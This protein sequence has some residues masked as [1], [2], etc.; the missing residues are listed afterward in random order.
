MS[1][2]KIIPHL[3]FDSA[4]EDAAKFYTSLVPGSGIGAVSRY[5]KAGF[6]VHGQ[7]EGTAMNVQMHLGGQPMI[8]LNGGPRFR[9]TPAVSY[10][11][12][13]DDRAALDHAWNALGAG[14]QIHMPLDTYAWAPRYGWLD[15]RWGVSWQ[16]S[17]GE[18][19][20]TG[21]QVMT[22]M[23]LFTGALAGQAEAAVA[24]YTALFPASG[25]EGIL[26]HDGSGADPAGTVMHAQFQLAGQTFM[27]GDSALAHDFTFTEANSFL[28]FCDDQAEIDHYWHALTSVP[29]AERCG[30]L[31]DRFGLSWQIIPRHL[32][33]LLSSPEP[34]V[35]ET[36]LSMGKIDIATLE[37][38]AK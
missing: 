9:P 6:E 10:F 24:Q 25:I 29:E 18:R 26:R 37:R 27:A 35:M 15:D 32:P 21:G 20:Q 4:A 8:A 17:L 11:L 12:T 13:F 28:V 36:F 22:P 14:G 2:H 7:R 31:K 34:K 1:T 23:L 30:W 38:A 16:L 33:Q 3:W 5:G 19:A